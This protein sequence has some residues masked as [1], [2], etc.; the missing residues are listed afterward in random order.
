MLGYYSDLGSGFLYPERAR[1]EALQYRVRIDPAGGVT[2]SSPAYNVI[3]DYA[4]VLRKIVAMAMNE[5]SLGNAGMLIDFNISEQGRNA[6]VFK[7]NISFAAALKQ[8]LAWDGC[9]I[10]I[11]GTTLEVVWSVD[12]GRWSSLVGSAREVGVQLIGDM[13]KVGNSQQAGG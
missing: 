7:R 3:T 1:I 12:S 11:P 6:A 5:D 4:F 13:V 9:Y 10:S 8:P 2:F